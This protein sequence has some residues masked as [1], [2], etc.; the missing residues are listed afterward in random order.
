MYTY[1]LKEAVVV[2]IDAPIIVTFPYLFYRKPISLYNIMNRYALNII[3]II[4]VSR[5]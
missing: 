4:D 5:S 2:N 1:N 3:T